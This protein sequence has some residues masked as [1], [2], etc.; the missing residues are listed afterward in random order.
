[1]GEVNFVTV[2]QVNILREPVQSIEDME[3]GPAVKIKLSINRVI[4][5]KIQGISLENLLEDDSP[6]FVRQ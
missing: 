6:G 4:V 2:I 1:M 3:T 5:Q